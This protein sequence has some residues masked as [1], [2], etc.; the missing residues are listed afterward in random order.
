VAPGARLGFLRPRSLAKD[1]IRGLKRTWYEGAFAPATLS[2][3]L[4]SAGLPHGPHPDP[5][6]ASS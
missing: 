4:R 2:H 3:R 6:R 1:G 5:V